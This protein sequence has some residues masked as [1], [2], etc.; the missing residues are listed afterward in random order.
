MKFFYLLLCFLQVIVGLGLIVVVLV[1]ESKN[2]GL[3][4]Q[5]GTSTTS[6]FKGKAGREEHLNL[7]TRNFAIA[8]FVISLLVA[9]G[10]NRW[11]HW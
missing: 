10:T 4:G 9:F 5:I 2:E 3:T 7:L 11:Y 8:F 1:Q 6:S